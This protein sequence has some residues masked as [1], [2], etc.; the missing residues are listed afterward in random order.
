[1]LKSQKLSFSLLYS[2]V[3]HIIMVNFL[4]NMC[5]VCFNS[6]IL[7]DIQR[8]LIFLWYSAFFDIPKQ[9]NKFNENLTYL[10][11]FQ[12]VFLEKFFGSLRLH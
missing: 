12:R 11:N 7:L 1:M 10:K 5:C 9:N 2:S 8:S 4:D 3:F 6:P